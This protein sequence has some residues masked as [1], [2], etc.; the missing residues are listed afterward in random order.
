VHP[1]AGKTGADFKSLGEPPEKFFMRIS[2]KKA[3]F[4]KPAFFY[5]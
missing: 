2:K 5:Y 1:A 3:G 4:S